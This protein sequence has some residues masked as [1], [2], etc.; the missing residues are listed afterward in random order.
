L[1]SGAAMQG[2]FYLENSRLNKRKSLYRWE[3]CKG[4]SGPEFAGQNV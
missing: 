2:F 3:N 1:H 4:L